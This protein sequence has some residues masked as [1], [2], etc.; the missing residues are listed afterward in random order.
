M[1]T[2]NNITTRDLLNLFFKNIIVIILAAIICATGAYI[3]CE[4]FTDEKFVSQGSIIVTNGGII[5]EDIDG[6]PVNNTDIAA[7]VNHMNTVKDLLTTPGLYQKISNKLDNKY[8]AGQLMGAA[9]VSSSSEETLLLKISFELDTKKDA[10]SATQA[11]LEFA[12]DY[13][14]SFIPGTLAQES[15]PASNAYQ[16]APKTLTTTLTVGLFGAIITFAIVFLIFTLNATIKSDEDFSMHYDI[17]VLG[18]I[19]DFVETG[20]NQGKSASKSKSKARR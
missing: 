14:S 10:M 19:P 8:T 16:T 18:N 2:V 20:K 3:Y 4:N 9:T 6:K 13:I 12:P 7:S 17:P 15:A 11:F 5:T 1:C